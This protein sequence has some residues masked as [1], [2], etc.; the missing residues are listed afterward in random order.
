MYQYYAILRDNEYILSTVKRYDK[1]AEQHINRQLM[2][3]GHHYP[4]SNLRVIKLRKRA[5]ATD[6]TAWV[7]A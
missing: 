6:N 1:D 5:D 4:N 2:L 7:E 3:W